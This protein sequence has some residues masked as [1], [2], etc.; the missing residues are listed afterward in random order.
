MAAEAR[1]RRHEAIAASVHR[2]NVLGSACRVAQGLTDLV[3]VVFEHT[4][5]HH[6]LRPDL[7]QQRILVHHLTGVCHQIGEDRKGLGARGAAIAVS[8]HRHILI[9]SRRNGPKRHMES[10][11]IWPS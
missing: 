4:L 10:A 5:T 8:R 9:G 6:R 1:Y 7:L 3:D 2:G 11:D